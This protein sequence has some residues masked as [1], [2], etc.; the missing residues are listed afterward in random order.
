[1]MLHV[2]ASVSDANL[3]NDVPKLLEG[4]REN[5]SKMI[6]DLRQ[7]FNGAIVERTY[8]DNGEPIPNTNE[9]VGVVI[10]VAGLFDVNVRK[11]DMAAA[12]K[13]VDML[14]QETQVWAG[15]MVARRTTVSVSTRISTNEAV[16][17]VQIRTAQGRVLVDVETLSGVRALDVDGL[18]VPVLH[19][20]AAMMAPLQVQFVTKP[21]WW[22]A[23][24]FVQVGNRLVGSSTQFPGD[25]GIEG[26]VIL[27]IADQIEVS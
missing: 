24:G 4:S 23:S 3:A 18:E 2:D 11:V 15:S 6:S 12:V 27:S 25:K 10:S 1:V 9:N 22:E 8:D 7:A 5:R 20:S 16:K 17:N 19:E 14:A 21:S 13:A 26:L